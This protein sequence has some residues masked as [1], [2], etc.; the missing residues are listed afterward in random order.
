MSYNS[1]VHSIAITRNCNQCKLEPFFLNKQ[2]L[3]Y[4]FPFTSIGHFS[5]LDYSAI[6][7]PFLAQ[8]GNLPQ[9]LNYQQI[10][11][12]NTLSLHYLVIIS[13][14]KKKAALSDC[15][16]MRYGFTSINRWYILD[17]GMR[18]SPRRSFPCR[19]AGL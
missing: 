11:L 6:S 10:I 5:V 13:D 19:Q 9:T 2:I 14:I 18:P 16:P 15:L 12:T 3:C 4:F 7:V 8:S 17:S 1:H